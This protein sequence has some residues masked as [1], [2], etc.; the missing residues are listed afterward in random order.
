MA[1]STGLLKASDAAQKLGISSMTLKRWITAGKI[2]AKKISGRY[3]IRR[4]ELEAFIN[5]N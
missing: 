4:D 1:E 2:K 5:K 3:Y